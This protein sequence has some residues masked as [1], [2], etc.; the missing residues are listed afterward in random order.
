MLQCY[1]HATFSSSIVARLSLHKTPSILCSTTPEQTLFTPCQ[2]IYSPTL[3]IIKVIAGDMLRVLS[4]RVQVAIAPKEF[5]HIVSAGATTTDAT[6]L[7]LPVCPDKESRN[8]HR[9]AQDCNYC[10]AENDE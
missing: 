2:L 8:K 3:L 7:V 5:R 1:I 6:L 10:D 4:F 9:Q